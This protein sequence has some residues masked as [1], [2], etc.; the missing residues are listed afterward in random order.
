M[1]RAAENLTPE[2]KKKRRKKYGFLTLSPSSNASPSSPA[3]V[4]VMAVALSLATYL[5]NSYIRFHNGEPVI[6]TSVG[7]LQGNFAKS[8]EGRTYYEFLG[9]PYAE[10]PLGNLRFEV[11]PNYLCSQFRP[12]NHFVFVNTDKKCVV[13][14]QRPVAA[15]PWKGIRSAKDYGPPC[16]QLEVMVTAR[17]QGDEN[18]LFLNIFTPLKSQKLLPVLVFLHGGCK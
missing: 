2:L 15:K 12:A 3:A 6:S 9:V 16:M 4:A 11:C 8:R 14:I 17:V 13:F 7:R 5:Y 1:F 10:P 18:C